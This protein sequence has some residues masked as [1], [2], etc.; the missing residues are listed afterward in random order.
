MATGKAPKPGEFHSLSAKLDKAKNILLNQLPLQMFKDVC[1]KVPKSHRGKLVR[2]N[3]D[4]IDADAVL[5]ADEKTL[6]K[7][8]REKLKEFMTQ[9][10]WKALDAIDILDAV[11]QMKD[12]VLNPAAH[13]S[14]TPLFDAEVKKALT[15]V[16]RLE[17]TLLK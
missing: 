6:I 15:L 17:A 8:Q 4:D 13:W 12:R 9:D 7:Q 16:S 5:T 1:S 14:E 2:M 11:I 10:A 3:D